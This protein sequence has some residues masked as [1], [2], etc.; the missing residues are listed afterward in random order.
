MSEPPAIL[1]VDDVAMNLVVL[2]AQLSGLGYHLDR[3]SSGEQ[4]LSMLRHRAYAVM[5]L[6]VQM[7]GLDG[8]EVAR[9]AR[10][11]AETSEVPIVFV[12]SMSETLES[13]L[14]GYG[15]G[16]VDFLFKPVNTEILR[17]K[18]R[19]FVELFLSKCALASEIEAHKKTLAE[20]EAFNYSVSHDLRAPLRPLEGFSQALL[21]DYGERL[22]EPAKDM[23]H[24]MKRAAHHMNA[25]IS[26]LL[27]LSKLERTTMHLVDVDLAEVADAIVG[28]LRNNEP[29]RQVEVVSLRE[30]H[31]EADPALLRIA[32]ENLVRNA[33][34]FT[35]HQ[36]HPRIELGEKT[37]DREQVYFIRDNGAGF[38]PAQAKRLFQPF[39]RMHSS[40]DFEGTGIGLAIVQRIIRRHGGRVWAEAAL[41]QGASFY[42][43]LDPKKARDRVL[44]PRPSSPPRA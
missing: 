40:K 18:V 28:E 43:T 32:L 6:D 41:G 16:A 29:D 15:A 33:W 26:D 8:Y 22:D 42:F 37:V 14:S 7:P 19:V 10:A 27:K 12:T 2:E 34:K 23:L 9:R 35:Q 1:L 31:V 5:L 44:P 11:S 20:L 13:E 24:R 3:A 36:P 4:A 17:G 25:L 39:Q 38:D 30:A 21:E